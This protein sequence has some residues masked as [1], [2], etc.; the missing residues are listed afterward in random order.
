MILDA[1]D[2]IVGRFAT[3]LAK[4]AL[5]GEEIIVVN[6]EKAVI[7]GSRTNVVGKYRNWTQ[8]GAPLQGPYFPRRPDMIV[9]R[10]IRGMLPHKQPK[11][12]DA[13]KRVMCYI[14]IPEAYK[15]KKFETV[16]EAQVSM[17]PNLR[18]VTIGHISKQIGGK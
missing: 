18:Y 13:Y 16:K 12:K 2:L 14:G 10:M 17:L 1:T 6:S 11:G 15:D 9:R 3:V 4:R 7:S 8:R 5:M